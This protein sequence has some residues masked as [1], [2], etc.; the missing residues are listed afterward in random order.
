MICYLIIMKI[1]IFRHWILLKK[2]DNNQYGTNLLD[3]LDSC[4]RFLISLHSQSIQNHP[5]HSLISLTT[6]F[7][8][9]NDLTLSKKTK[10]HKSFFNLSES[11]SF[12][13]TLSHAYLTLYLSEN[14]KEISLFNLTKNPTKPLQPFNNRH[15][16]SSSIRR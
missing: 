10:T 6:C 4:N 13:Y 14:L 15:H 12:S 5:R 11:L 3:S 16:S 9:K 7:S 8:A 2:N 1:Y